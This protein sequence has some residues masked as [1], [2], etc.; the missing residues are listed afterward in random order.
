MI[1]N[2]QSAHLNCD[3]DFLHVFS[4]FFSAIFSLLLFCLIN[5]KFIFVDIL[6]TSEHCTILH[7][8]VQRLCL[9]L[10]SV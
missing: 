5:V 10:I 9:Y 6:K 3:D 4:L 1:N 7:F 2:T 8:F